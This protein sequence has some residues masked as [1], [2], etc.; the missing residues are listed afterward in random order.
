MVRTN[1]AGIGRIVPVVF[2]SQRL[3]IET[4]QS[5]IARRKPDHSEMIFE[6]AVNARSYQQ[7]VEIQLRESVVFAV[8]TVKR[9]VDS[10]P[11]VAAAIEEER[12]DVVV[13]DRPFVRRIVEIA[14][15]QIGTRIESVQSVSGP[16]PECIV[17]P[18]DAVDEVVADGMGI[19]LIVFEFAEFVAIVSVHAGTGP[20]PHE[21]LTVAS[22]TIDDPL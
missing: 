3:G 15:E 9:T 1:A 10:D 11:K 12:F 14:G 13:A 16:D 7:T 6:Y 2:I 19:V 21:S 17:F 5:G 20:E 22:D 8:I 18:G 4:D